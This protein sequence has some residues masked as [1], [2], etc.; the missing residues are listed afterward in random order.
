MAF[1]DK[2]VLISELLSQIR[3]DTD[4]FEFEMIQRQD[5]KYEHKAKIQIF[6]NIK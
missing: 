6:K 5:G 1:F 2:H 4:S 3:N